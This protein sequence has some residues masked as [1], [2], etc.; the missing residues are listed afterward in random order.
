MK[1]EKVKYNAILTDN[2]LRLLQ[3]LDDNR[4][5]IPAY[6][7]SRMMYLLSTIMTHPQDKHPGAWSVLHMN[8]LRAVVPNA[9]QY[10]DYLNEE[11]VIEVKNHFAGRNSRLYRIAK[12]YQG[13]A[14]FRTI[15]DMALLNRIQEARCEIAK[16]NS[17]KYPDLN[18]MTS[19]VRI[20]VS[21]AHET[22]EAMYQA[23]EDKRAAEARRTYSLAEVE[24]IYRGE[25]F[26]TVNDTNFRY[27]T[28]FTRLPSELVQHLTI[29]GKPLQELDICNSQIFF[30][31]CLFDPTPEVTRVMRSYLGQKLTIDTKRLQLSDKYDVKRYALLATSGEFYEGMM[32]LFNLSDRDEVKELCFTVL[33]SKNTA[34]RYS[35]DVRMF[36][37]EFPS[38]FRMFT[39]IKSEGHNRLAVLLQRIESDVILN[40]CVPAI[41]KQLPDVMFTTKHD[42]I[43][44]AIL[45]V[46][47]DKAGEV[48]RVMTETIEEV[49]GLKPKIKIKQAQILKSHSATSNTSTPINSNQSTPPLNTFYPIIRTKT[50]QLVENDIVRW[51]RLSGKMKR[52]IKKFKKDNQASVTVVDDK[53]SASSLAPAG[54]LIKESCKK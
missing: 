33:F 51:G 9:Y 15:T 14:V 17:R 13:P 12:E 40:H 6:K 4:P 53:K 32:K 38:V 11:G 43:L 16:H 34:V 25:I 42:S 8:Y 24:K 2:L 22:I 20:D 52:Q 10:I 36:R 37:D 21:A 31:V 29:E 48:A 45:L 23:T 27:D 18:M 19:R 7:R 5:P 26:H 39:F 50:L 28:N 35:K 41:R 30:S 47:G 54:E 3:E 1:K 44:P 46:A 49:T